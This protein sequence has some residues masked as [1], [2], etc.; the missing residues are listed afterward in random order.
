MSE[1]NP[2]HRFV[3]VDLASDK[4]AEV[5]VKLQRKEAPANADLSVQSVVPSTTERHANQDTEETTQYTQ[6]MGQFHVLSA[7]PSETEIRNAIIGKWKLKSAER[8]GDRLQ[9]DASDLQP[10]SSIEFDADQVSFGKAS[11]Q[12]TLERWSYRLDLDSDPMRLELS[13]SGVTRKAIC[14]YVYGSDSPLVGQLS[15]VLP[16]EGDDF[17]AG[18]DTNGNDNLKLDYQRDETDPDWLEA[19][20]SRFRKNAGD[21]LLHGNAGQQELARELQEWAAFYLREASLRRKAQATAATANELRVAGKLQQA[22]LAQHDADELRSQADAE[23]AKW[24]VSVQLRDLEKQRQDWINEKQ[25]QD[26]IK[27]LTAKTA[28]PSG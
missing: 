20:A 17:P 16:E 13:R 23:H 25:R 10:Y 12:A 15:I 22:K 26:W 28:N 11:D 7:V 4:I 19:E 2:S 18:F 6:E 14:W 24:E 8:R 27:L 5:T 21:L 3:T 1:E 9:S